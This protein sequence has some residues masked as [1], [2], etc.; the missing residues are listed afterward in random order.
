MYNNKRKSIASLVLILVLS[1]NQIN[2]KKKTSPTEKNIYQ[3]LELL[4]QTIAQ[5]EAKGFRKK[6]DFLQ[7]AQEALKAAIPSIVD[8]H[9]AFFPP[10]CLPVGRGRGGDEVNLKELNTFV[11]I[12]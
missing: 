10:A 5:I 7:F 6:L 1:F 3:G 4:S 11:L 2:S 8:A 12:T 9:S